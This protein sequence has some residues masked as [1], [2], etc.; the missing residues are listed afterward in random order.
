MQQGQSRVSQDAG[1]LEQ[2]R[3]Q[4]TKDR[5]TLADTQRQ[6]TQ[7]QQQQAPA[8]SSAIQLGAALG[9]AIERPSR[10]EQLLTANPAAVR[11]QLNAQG[12]TIGKLI[13]VTA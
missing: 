10:A 3:S 13:D 7:A 8:Q 9:S 2:S 5:Q 12:Q 11:P 1:R 6:S 4:L